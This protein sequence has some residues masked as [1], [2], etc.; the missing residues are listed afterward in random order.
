[1]SLRR[2]ARREESERERVDLN[3]VVRTVT[4]AL[5]WHARRSGAVVKLEL[6]AIPT[7]IADRTQIEQVVY[8][9][10]QNAIEAVS[11]PKATVHDVTI[12][13]GI[14][15]PDAV[16]LTVTDTGVGLPVDADRLFAGFYSTK[17]DGIGMGLAISRSIIEAHGG[18]LTVSPGPR[19]G[20]T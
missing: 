6:T 11:V 8:N 3:E 10:L 2:M 17:P 19:S 14:A 4:S 12:Q 1:K 5:A 7:V 20:A 15:G 13:S 18:R 9:I 16:A